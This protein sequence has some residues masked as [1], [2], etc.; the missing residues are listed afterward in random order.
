[1]TFKKGIERLGQRGIRLDKTPILF[2]EAKERS[3]AAV[4]P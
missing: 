4:S 2:R 3:Q 1:M